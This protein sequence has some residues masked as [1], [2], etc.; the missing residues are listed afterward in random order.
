MAKGLDGPAG[1]VALIG[2]AAH[3]MLPHQGLGACQGIEDAYVLSLLLSSPLTNITNLATALEFYDEVRRP[4]AQKVADSSRVVGEMLDFTSY[5]HVGDS[6]E[7]WGQ[8]MG[9]LCEWLRD[10]GGTFAVG[11]RAMDMLKGKA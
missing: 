6:D 1:N 11:E 4:L 2:D 8:A 9:G 5:E 3:A 7:E 10:E